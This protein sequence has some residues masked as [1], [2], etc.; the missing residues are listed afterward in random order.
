LPDALLRRAL[1]QGFRKLALRFF[2]RADLHS[3]SDS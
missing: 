1:R 3:I 2:Q